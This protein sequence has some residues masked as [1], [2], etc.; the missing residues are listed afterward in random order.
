MVPLYNH[1][2]CRAGGGGGGVGGGEGTGTGT[3]WLE[4]FD[5]CSLHSQFQASTARCRVGALVQSR[6]NCL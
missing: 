1:G 3:S 5:Q 4:V 2:N 6:Q